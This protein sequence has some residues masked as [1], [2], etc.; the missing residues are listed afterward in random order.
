MTVPSNVEHFDAV[1]VGCG[2]MGSSVSYNLVSKGMKV[3]TLERFDLNHELGSS[4]GGT[5]II[6]LVY[7][8]DPRYVPLL[9]RAFASWGELQEKSGRTLMRLTGGLMIGRKDGDLVL[10][11]L[12][13][14]REHGLPHRIL[15]GAE[16]NRAFPAFR[17]GEEQSAVHEE[18]AG[19]LFPE[20]CVLAFYESAERAG[21]VFRFSETLSSWRGTDEGIE[22]ATD[23]GTYGADRL[24][25]C[26]GPWTGELLGGLI[27][28]ECERQVP[29][30]FD[31]RGNPNF[32]PDRMPIFVLEEDAETT[33]YG[34]PD[35]GHG[36][37]IARHH[38]GE[39]VQPDAVDRQ[40]KE[41]DTAPVKGFISRRL[42]GLSPIPMASKTCLYTNTPDSNFVLDFL[43]SDS[44][45]IVVSVCSGHGFKFA[46]VI[47][48]VVAD[49]VQKGRTPYDISFLRIGRF[50]K[51]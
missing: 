14:A 11:V 25:I 29:L 7:A 10:G 3:L 16:V 24:V 4:H 13:S 9:R 37:K 19:I 5:R 17:V 35:V 18:S 22:V 20:E 50:P 47:G 23:R 43:P 48:E 38:G 31:S 45:V 8:E 12:R 15:T 21:C 42:S 41:S 49:L 2:A 1:V 28:L 6:R 36:V 51:G 30:W 46:S 40:V 39:S 27:P 32:G 44:R 34:I 33:F 26:A